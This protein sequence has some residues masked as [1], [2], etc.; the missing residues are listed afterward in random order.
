MQVEYNGRLI[1]SD[2]FR[3]VL[4]HR[5]GIMRV[6]EGF[7]NYQKLL[8]TGDWFEKQKNVSRETLPPKR[9][10]KKAVNDANGS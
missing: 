9:R 4:Y 6:A 8:S 2:N 7:E 10:R 1:D 3:V 5:D